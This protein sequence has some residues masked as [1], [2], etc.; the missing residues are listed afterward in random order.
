MKNLR[1]LIIIIIMI[2]SIVCCLIF[3]IKNKSKTESYYDVRVVS[4]SREYFSISYAIQKLY[5]YRNRD[6][7]EN[8]YNILDDEYI[9]ENG[10]TL[11]N[12]SE[13]FI[14]KNTNFI[15]QKIYAYDVDEY[16]KIYLVKGLSSKKIEEN[17]KVEYKDNICYIVKADMQ[18]STFSISK[19]IQKYKKIFNKLL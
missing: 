16:S 10:I 3:I 2:I 17:E 18:N 9:N 14:E 12:L 8:I 11:E 15:P 6:K 1:L 7:F 13:N 4:E 5:I 19:D